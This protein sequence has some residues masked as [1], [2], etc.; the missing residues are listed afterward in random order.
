MDRALALPEAERAAVIRAAVDYEDPGPGGFYDDPG[1]PG[2]APHLVNG[3]A[4]GETGFSS[5]NRISQRNMAFTTDEKEGV[6]FEYEGLDPKASYRVKLSLVRPSYLPRYAAFQP[7]KTESIFAG[8]V[9][10]AKDLELPLEKAEFFEYDIPPSV[11]RDGTLRL[12]VQKSAGVGEGPNPQ[13]TLWRDT[14]GWGTLCSEVCLMK[15]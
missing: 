9:C 2:R 3:C 1:V 7:Q 4:F 10:L 11:T 13:V 14:G 6:A 12:W 8:D 5:A 15:K